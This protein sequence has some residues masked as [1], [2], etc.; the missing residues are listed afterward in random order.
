MRND[1]RRFLE[2]Q[3]LPP[4]LVTKKIWEER[5]EDIRNIEQYLTRNGVVIRKFF[6]HV[7]KEEQLN[8]FLSRLDDP[9]KNWK[10]SAA[11]AASRESWPNYMQA[12]EDTI[13]HTATEDAPWYVVPADNKWF[14][15]IVV[16]AVVVDT[17]ASLNL[18]YP[19]VTDAQQKE[20]AEVRRTFLG[21]K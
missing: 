5:Y 12:Y 17:L 10:F 11:D 16:A 20:L 18:Q 4:Q 1:N 7:S 19:K 15:R 13:R 2:G 6:L 3:K 14:T 9:D 21:D 8:R